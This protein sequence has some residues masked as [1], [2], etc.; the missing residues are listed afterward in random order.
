VAAAIPRHSRRPVYPFEIDSCFSYTFFYSS[1]YAKW[2]DTAPYVGCLFPFGQHVEFNP[3][4]EHQNNT[5]KSPNQQLN[6][7][8][9]MLNLY[10]GH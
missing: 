9:L 5:G 2:N 3:Y 6:Q 7:L 4:Y 1:Q 10:F 8:G